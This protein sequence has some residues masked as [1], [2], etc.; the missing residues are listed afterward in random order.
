MWR[1]CGFVRSKIDG[2][3]AAVWSEKW[4]DLKK[5]RSFP[6]FQRFFQPK[7]SDLKNKKV[8]SKIST[9]FPV[10]IKLLSCDFNQCHLDGPPL[11]L[12]S[13]LNSMGP[14][15][16][17]PPAPPLVGP[18]LSVVVLEQFGQDNSQFENYYFIVEIIYSCGARRMIRFYYF[19]WSVF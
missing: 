4:C 7:S 6:K 1:N 14:R 19:F 15:V 12:M 9:V 3:N 18:A 10:E 13:P 5:K 17:V 2:E 16:I 8:F 11:E